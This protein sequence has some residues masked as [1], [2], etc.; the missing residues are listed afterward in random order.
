MMA[1]DGAQIGLHAA[2][3]PVLKQEPLCPAVKPDVS[4]QLPQP[5]ALCMGQARKY[6]S[7]R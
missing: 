4:A 2:Q 3:P 1:R 7:G 5:P 6:I